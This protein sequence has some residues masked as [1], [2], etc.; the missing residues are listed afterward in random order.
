M[1]SEE[2]ITAMNA[3]DEYIDTL[4]SLVE[5]LPVYNILECCLALGASDE[6]IIKILG[7]MAHLAEV[8]TDPYM[9]LIAFHRRKK[10]H[11]YLKSRGFKYFIQL[12]GVDEET[13][14]EV[15]VGNQPQI[16]DNGWHFGVYKEYVIMEADYVDFVVDLYVAE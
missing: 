6:T 10:L 11:K 4:K 1:F 2:L 8:E 16:R 3:N 5:M 12:R 14:A 9:E 7:D 13:G 15:F